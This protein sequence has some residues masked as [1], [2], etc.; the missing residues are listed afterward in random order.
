MQNKVHDADL[1]EGTEEQHFKTRSIFLFNY[2][3]LTLPA[4]CILFLATCKGFLKKSGKFVI[5]RILTSGR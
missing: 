4:H 1:D 2:L 3:E 5:Y